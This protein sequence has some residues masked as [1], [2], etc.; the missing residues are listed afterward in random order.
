MPRPHYPA[1][2]SDFI[3]LK[4]AGLRRPCRLVTRQHIFQ[5]SALSSPYVGEMPTQ[6]V[7]G[8]GNQ[9]LIPETEQKKATTSKEG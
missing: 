9:G 2:R 4:P 8:D 6:L 5:I 1:G 3:R 7:T